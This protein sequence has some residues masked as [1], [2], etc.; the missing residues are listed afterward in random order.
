M[1]AIR[2]PLE[3]SH[4]HRRTKVRDLMLA[5]PLKIYGNGVRYLRFDAYAAILSLLDLSGNN[6]RP[7]QPPAGLRAD[8]GEERSTTSDGDGWRSRSDP[9]A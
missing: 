9:G 7:L 2:L 5:S 1:R 6:V 4:T 3:E 8:P